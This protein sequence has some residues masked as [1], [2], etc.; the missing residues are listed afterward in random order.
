M[1]ID[2]PW[3]LLNILSFQNNNTFERNGRDC[4]SGWL[5][6]DCD[7]SRSIDINILIASR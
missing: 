2:K 5:E 6:V 3:L 4:L 7:G 1:S